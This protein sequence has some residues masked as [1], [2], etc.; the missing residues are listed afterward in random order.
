MDSQKRKME[1]LEEFLHKQ[2]RCIVEDRPSPYPRPKDG[3]VKSITNTHIILE[4]K[5]KI[6]ALLLSDIRRIELR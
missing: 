3:I 1:Q 6:I 5:D 4:Q 2:V